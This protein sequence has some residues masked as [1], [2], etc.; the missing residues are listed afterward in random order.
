MPKAVASRSKLAKPLPKRKS[1]PVKPKA[2]VTSANDT[3]SDDA[4]LPPPSLLN[5]AF[6]LQ[7][8]LAKL[9]ASKSFDW[10][11]LA[12]KF[13]EEEGGTSPKGKKKG[14]EGSVWSGAELHDLYHYVS[15]P[16][17]S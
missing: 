11:T 8:V 15:S 7:I 6:V 12:Q 10:F 13:G 4:P 5:K 16:S 17:L 3:E 2:K 9:E 1:T 14:K